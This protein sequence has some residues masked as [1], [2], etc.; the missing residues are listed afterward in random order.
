MT[1]NKGF[2]LIELLAVIV[3]LAIITVIATPIITGI[4]EDV[5]KAAFERSVDGIVKGTET[6]IALKLSSDGYTYIITDGVIDNLDEKI[7]VS[8]T[9]GFTG[10]I[11]YDSDANV[12]YAIHNDKWCRIKNDLNVSTIKYVDGECDLTGSSIL[13]YEDGHILYFD[14][15]NGTK[16]TN[17]HEDNSI[18]AYN[19]LESTKTTDNQN[20]CLKFYA[21][22]DKVENNTL[23][24][25]LDHNITAPSYWAEDNFMGSN[26]NGPTTI[27]PKLKSLTSSWS[28]VEIIDNYTVAQEG[29]GNYTILYKDENYKARLITA[30]EVAEIVKMSDFDEVTYK[31]NFYFD[32]LNNTESDACKKNSTTGCSYGWLYN[33]TKADCELYGC[34]NNADVSNVEGYWTATSAPA[35]PYSA[36]RITYNSMFSIGDFV[37][38]ERYGVRPVI[39]VLKTKLK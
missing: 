22:N 29:Y 4:I 37:K 20:S 34:L 8:N 21:F 28:G 6:D 13:L 17:Y 39:E 2:T 19:G 24:L 11:K 7:K 32:S 30:N 1:R 38:A 31:Q 26:T 15:I 36:W 33:R 14:V 16:C 12:S 25:L 23:N 3:I 9:K 5:K 10:T 35:T 27:L 18:T